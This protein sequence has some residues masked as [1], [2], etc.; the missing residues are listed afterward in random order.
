[1][2]KMTNFCN[3]LITDC[4]PL[5]AEKDKHQLECEKKKKSEQESERIKRNQETDALHPV[6]SVTAPPL[7]T[8][9]V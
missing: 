4:K 1:M 3:L 5:M 2:K 6:C 7:K 8:I 9:L